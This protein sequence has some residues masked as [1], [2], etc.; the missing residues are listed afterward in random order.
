VQ[1]RAGR[2]RNINYNGPIGNLSIDLSGNVTTA[3]FD[4]FGSTTPAATSP[5]G[6]ITV[7][8]D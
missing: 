7:G 4:R 2:G 8:S 5:D 1:R 3:D 6:S